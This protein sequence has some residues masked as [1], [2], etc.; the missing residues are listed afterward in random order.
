M[1]R[2]I[3]AYLL[4]L[5]TTATL[6]AAIPHHPTQAPTKPDPPEDPFIA[7]EDGCWGEAQAYIDPR[8]G[9]VGL[10]FFYTCPLLG[11]V[12]PGFWLRIEPDLAV[13]LVYDWLATDDGPI[14]ECP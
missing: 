2:T 3:T 12:P 5:L 8:T 7:F 14:G 1:K 11:V 9:K 6:A 10:E 4:G 13:E